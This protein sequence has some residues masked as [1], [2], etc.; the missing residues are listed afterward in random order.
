MLDFK[1]LLKILSYVRIYLNNIIYIY[2]YVNVCVCVHVYVYSG[3]E[4]LLINRNEKY[5][6]YKLNLCN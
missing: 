4:N 3:L 5:K 2:I 1:P 6:K